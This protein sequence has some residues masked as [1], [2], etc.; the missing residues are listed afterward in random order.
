MIF[1]EV[2]Q[3]QPYDQENLLDYLFC[4]VSSHERLIIWL[5]IVEQYSHDELAVQQVIQN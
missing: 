2:N 4:N 3:E 5:F 1:N